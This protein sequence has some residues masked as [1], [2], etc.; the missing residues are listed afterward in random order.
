[1]FILHQPMI[2]HE[3]YRDLYGLF[4]IYIDLILCFFNEFMRF[5]WIHAG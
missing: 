2:V 3:I 1:M 5:M 4:M